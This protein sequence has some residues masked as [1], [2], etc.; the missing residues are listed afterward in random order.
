MVTREYIYD[1]LYSAKEAHMNMLRVWGG[2]NRNI[3]VI[4]KRNLV[5]YWQTNLK[6]NSIR[7][8]FQVAYMNPM[9]SMI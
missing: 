2:K 1:I 7:R 9:I 5:K 4:T 3:I 8:K 6:V